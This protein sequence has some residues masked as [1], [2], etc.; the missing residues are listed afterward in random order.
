MAPPL[1]SHGRHTGTRHA[2]FQRCPPPALLCCPW[3]GPPPAMGTPPGLPGSGP[4]LRGQGCPAGSGPVFGAPWPRPPC[5]PGCRR[6]RPPARGVVP[7]RDGKPWQVALLAR[8]PAASAGSTRALTGTMTIPQPCG[9]PVDELE[10]PFVTYQQKRSEN[11]GHFPQND[12]L[13][14]GV[15]PC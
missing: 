14:R 5:P 15:G 9:K 6:A 3:R 4:L 12:A 2:L 7:C 13:C 1:P 11:H 8:R 10:H